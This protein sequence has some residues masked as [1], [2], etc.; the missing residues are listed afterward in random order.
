MDDA[1]D[2]AADSVDDDDVDDDDIAAPVDD[3]DD[4]DTID[5]LS[6]FF[7]NVATT[8]GG[9]FFAPINRG[10]GN[11]RGRRMICNANVKANNDD[12]DADNDAE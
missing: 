10:H 9:A 2:G 7:A 5:T 3:N 6:A 4:D 1:V 11:N 12:D 8:V